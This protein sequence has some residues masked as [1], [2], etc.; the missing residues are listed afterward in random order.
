MMAKK[1][2]PGLITLLALGPIVHG[3]DEAPDIL[4]GYG[5]TTWGMSVEEL[6]EI[7]PEL[8]KAG[9]RESEL[10]YSVKGE[11]AITGKTFAFI[12][13]QLY[14]LTLVLELPDRPDTSRIDKVR[15]I[16]YDEDK[17]GAGIIQEK[18]NQKYFSSAESRDAIKKARINI[19]VTAGQQGGKIYVNYSNRK[20]RAEAQRSFQE[21]K[22]LERAE[23]EKERAATSQFGKRIEKINNLALDEEL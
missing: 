16:E 22:N 11:G 15:G 3:Q 21:K 7:I 20:L 5:K 10:F 9:G 14:E 1:L 19:K 18:I 2:I 13:D 4:K 6:K 17:E 23:A 12:N 8:K